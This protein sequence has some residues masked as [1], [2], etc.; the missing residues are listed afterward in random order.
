MRNIDFLTG[1][2]KGLFQ[3]IPQITSADP[4][5]VYREIPMEVAIY[6]THGKYKFVNKLY[7]GDDKVTKRLLGQ[8]DDFYAELRGINSDSL[9]K[10][11]QYFQQWAGSTL[12]IGC[13]RYS[14]LQ[15]Y[16][17]YFPVPVLPLMF[18]SIPLRRTENH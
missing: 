3:K 16:V 13:Q 4:Y 2:L 14:H 17:N 10:R 12:Q 18:L 8:T 15:L 5:R 6:D 7:G 1:F 9:Q 11:R